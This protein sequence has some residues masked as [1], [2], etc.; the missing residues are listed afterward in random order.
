[1]ITTIEDLKAIIPTIIGDNFDLYKSD[2]DSAR[3]WLYYQVLGLLLGAKIADDVI[4]DKYV[5]AVIAYKAYTNII[6][7]LD[8]I[9]N[10]NGFIVVSDDRFAP[11]SR[12]RVKA[13]IQASEQST[14]TSLSMLYEYLEDSDLLSK[15]WA[16]APASTIVKRSFLPTLRQF[17]QYYS[18]EGG[19]CQW[20]FSKF[21]HQLVMVKYFEARFTAPFIDEI[22]AVPV[23]NITILFRYAFA[24]AM[25]D[26]MGSYDV[27]CDRII[28]ELRA[29]PQEYPKYT[30]VEVK[31]FESTSIIS[32]L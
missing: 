4:F 23:S 14:T 1:M 3:D 6:P 18:F 5:S 28:S 9:N 2:I 8:T 21:K 26:D 20:L 24:A 12:E 19:Y 16:D 27:F 29:N 13:L 25:S 15:M 11:A 31:P 17:R 22:L 32:L 10:G 7:K 30:P